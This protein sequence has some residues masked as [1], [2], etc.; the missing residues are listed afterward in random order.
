MENSGFT[1]G[2]NGTVSGVFFSRKDADRAYDSLIKRGHTSDDISVLM[3]D[4]TLSQSEPI[5]AEPDDEE[6]AL[7]RAANAFS[8]VIISITSMISI[9]GLGVSISRKLQQLLP[10]DY[11]NTQKSD[12]I[13]SSGVAEQHI[14]AYDEH[15]QEGGII[16]SVDPRNQEEK[17]EIVRDF[18]A[19]N[20]TDILGS[21]GYAELD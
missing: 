17:R 12:A 6:S 10:K 15:M 8:G 16:I 21:D 1:S 3:S 14:P 2:T 9:P 18:R 13:R 4:E 20:G 7:S 11:I 5:H 19:F